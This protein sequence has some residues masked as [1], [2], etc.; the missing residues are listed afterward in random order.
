M[1]SSRHLSEAKKAASLKARSRRTQLFD[2]EL[3]RCIPN[4]RAYAYSLCRDKAVAEDLLQETLARAMLYHTHFKPGTNMRAW[5]FRI[6]RN[7]FFESARVSKKRREA[8]PQLIAREASESLETQLDYI[9]LKEL[10]E[11]VRG[12]PLAQRRAINLVGRLGLTYQEAAWIEKCAVG[13][14]KSRVSRAR[15]TLLRLWE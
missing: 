8:L 1:A 11:L 14:M 10:T 2:S 7:L 12:L 13:T 9:H 5:T 15:E 6:L 4:L 3:L